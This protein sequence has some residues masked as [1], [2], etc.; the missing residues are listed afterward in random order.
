MNTMP[1][2]IP[3]RATVR[4]AYR[5]VF[6]DFKGFF[7]TTW[8]IWLLLLLCVEVPMGFL[9][10]QMRSELGSD[11]AV[12]DT[13]AVLEESGLVEKPQEKPSVAQGGAPVQA[14]AEKPRKTI[15]LKTA[16]MVM[17]V[18]IIQVLLLFSFVVA[19]YRAL[20]LHEKR[21]S[22]IAPRLGRNEWHYAWTNMKAGFVLAPFFIFIFLGIAGMAMNA[23]PEVTI[24]GVDIA[25]LGLGLVAL[26][27]LQARLALAYPATAVGEHITPLKHAWDLS[28]GLGWRILGGNLLV[29]LPLMSG[30]LLFAALLSKLV[31]WLAPLPDPSLAQA[32]QAV[33][34]LVTYGQVL[35]KIISNY[36]ILVF[37]GVLSAFHAR[38]Y[39]TLMRGHDEAV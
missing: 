11:G 26:F 21:G 2:S 16:A 25:V 6:S 15:S 31:D 28:R 24:S 23:G 27:Y 14:Q 33:P 29:V 12:T 32:Q 20:L 38:I 10:E 13:R 39:A 35:M 18:D 4:D 5:D 34:A 30:L 37:F 19:W 22:I 17:V 36:F 7:K 9:T 8:L 3:I 1:A